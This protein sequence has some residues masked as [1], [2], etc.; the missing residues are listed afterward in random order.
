MLHSHELKNVKEKY[1]K[2][3]LLQSDNALS[4]KKKSRPELVIDEI[5]SY[6]GNIIKL[7][8]IFGP[9]PTYGEL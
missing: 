6:M 5:A 8:L 1:Y 7:I 2:R 9:C 3:V 4:D